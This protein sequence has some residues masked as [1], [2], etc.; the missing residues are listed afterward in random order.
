M[1]AQITLREWRW[2]AL[3]AALVMA[4]TV[5]PYLVA[6][7]SQTATWRFSG[8]LIAVD[9]GNSYIAKMGQGARGAWLFRLPYSSE[10]QSGVLVYSFYLLLG[11]LAGPE[12]GAQVFAYHAARLLFGLVFLLTTFYFLSHFLPHFPQRFLALVLVALGGGLGWLIAPLDVGLPVEF[13]SPEAFSFLMLFVLPHLVAARCLLLLGLLAYLRDRPFWSGLALF[14]VSLIQPLYVLAAWAV[15]AATAGA[16][17]LVGAIGERGKEG[18]WGKRLWEAARQVVVI[19]LMSAPVVAYTA[20]AF[21]LDPVMRVWSAQNVLASA[22]PLHYLAGYGVLLALAVPGWRVL[23]RERPRLARFVLVW[24]LL[25]PL[26]LYAPVATQRRFIEG[27]Y[28]ALV[29]V[30]VLGLTTALARWRRVLVPLTLA[31]SLPSTA[32]LLAGAWGGAQQLRPPIFLPADQ[33][34]VFDWLRANAPP[35]SVG[36]GAFETGNA[37]PAY[38][39]LIAY[40]GHG[41]ETVRAAEKQAQVAR[42]YQAATPE[43]E[44]LQLLAEGRIAYVL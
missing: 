3:V 16:D 15:I 12:H 10:P 43:A 27:F 21:M 34:A 33:L 44:R 30:A 8:F 9:D 29:A 36:L 24:A 13:Y 37:L 25:L 35:D 1:A 31:V 40:I 5:A 22:H 26:M 17:A 38:T 42:F 7:N 23:R 32:V 14:G 20:L 2:A 19:V 18:N 4:L 28:V 41:P 6:Y 11:K 39:P